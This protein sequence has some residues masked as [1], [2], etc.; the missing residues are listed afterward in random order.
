MKDGITA[1]MNWEL[2]EKNKNLLLKELDSSITEE[3]KEELQGW[4]ESHPAYRRLYEGLREVSFLKSVILS[5]DD[6]LMKQGWNRLKFRIYGRRKIRRIL[7]IAAVFLLLFTGGILIYQNISGP[8]KIGEMEGMARIYWADGGITVLKGKSG[9]G[10]IG[11]ED[12]L[13]ISRVLPES[14]SQT[15]NRVVIPEGMTHSVRLSDGT[16]ICLNA[17]SELEIPV[18]YSDSNRYVNM[19]GEAYFD[20][21]HVGGRN[22][23]VC[24]GDVKIRVLGTKFNVRAY[25]DEKMATTL[26][27]GRLKVHSFK[28][29]VVLEAGMQAVLEND[30]GFSV[31]IVDTGIYTAW[32]SERF[33]Y[34]N[35]SVKYILR[36]AGRWYGV[37]FIVDASE[38]SDMRIT[39]DIPRYEDYGEFI[40]TVEKTGKLK[41]RKIKDEIHVTR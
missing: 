38:V 39:M 1:E 30:G 36:D 25:S 29:Q 8:K 14:L 35:A 28:E 20:V 5:E 23:T 12:T 41:F 2:I 6:K 32:M 24:I 40:R 3:E 17:G 19:K 13:V 7:R 16:L 37:N 27:E 34:D 4:L 31:E 21:S 10:N 33:V 9:S 11:N 26:T 15:Y 22:F 18:D